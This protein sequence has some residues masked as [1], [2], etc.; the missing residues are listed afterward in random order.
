MSN[1]PNSKLKSLLPYFILAMF[2]AAMGIIFNQQ[3]VTV[4]Y[5]RS[6]GASQSV[7]IEW[8]HLVFITL[9][10]ISV[11]PLLKE[12]LG[13]I[14][15]KVL[16]SLLNNIQFNRFSTL[17]R[18]GLFLLAGLSIVSVL[19][20]LSW[21]RLLPDDELN[22]KM[23]EFVSMVSNAREKSEHFTNVVNVSYANFSTN[24]KQHL[25]DCVTIVEKLKAAGAKAVYLSLQELPLDKDLDS[26]IVKLMNSD[27]VVLAT[28]GES[29]RYGSGEL[30][31]K[32][33][34]GIFIPL[35]NEKSLWASERLASISYGQAWWPLFHGVLRKYYGYPYYQFVG[36]WGNDILIGDTK[37]SISLSSRTSSLY[38][39]DQCPVFEGGDIVL[40]RGNAWAFGH[41]YE[42]YSQ[43]RSI[44]TRDLWFYKGSSEDTLLHY[45]SYLDSVKGET[46]PLSQVSEAALHSVFNGKVV[47]MGGNFGR[48]GGLFTPSR[49]LMI[50]TE[51]ILSDH[52]IHKTDTGFI[53]LSII[54]LV[55]AG[56]IAYH[57]R[58]FL[59][60]LLM[61]VLLMGVLL[62]GYFFYQHLNILI[63]II[64]PLLSVGVALIVFPAINVAH[65]MQGQTLITIGDVNTHGNY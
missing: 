46:F 11:V 55:L 65:R 20:L 7:N 34:M 57:T 49:A 53:W 61:I 60:F 12:I 28:P 26:L 15:R 54:S 45:T 13:T 39:R 5:P 1:K 59:S 42:G 16:P 64:Y 47:F 40:H 62:T 29:I 19:V 51:S 23:Y 30:R 58:P 35:V 6:S 4:R 8:L 44:H 52:M 17:R 22:G 41:G 56:L 10:L 37:L 31:D 36:L 43:K 3:T 27:I 48:E 14:T 21:T 32:N 18:I 24:P 63:D 9:S 33:G 25:R 38:F 2:F 50:A